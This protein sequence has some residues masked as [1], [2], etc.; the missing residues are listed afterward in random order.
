MDLFFQQLVNGLSLGALYGLIAVGYTVVYG[1]LQ[2][3]N[4]AHGEVFM[5]GAFGSFSTWVLLGQPDSWSLPLALLV[6]LPLMILGGVV[7]AVGTALLM[8]RFAY[9]PLR[10]AP[11]LAPLISAIGVSIALQEAVRLYY[12]E[13]P[14]FPSARS[15][16]PFPH[17][18]GISGRSVDLGI[19]QMQNSAV[20]TLAALVVCTAL[21]GWFVNRTRTGRAMKATS[22]DPDTARLM[23]INVDRMIMIAFAAGATLAAVAGSLTVCG[24]TTS[25]SRWVSSPV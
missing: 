6:M 21:L 13:I 14:G 18:E 5:I 20:F 16:I 9:R 25:I 3:I 23:G 24:T 2:L 19:V 17:V 8:E 1:I 22:Q 11:R 4:F 7:A 15:G 12:G 10:G